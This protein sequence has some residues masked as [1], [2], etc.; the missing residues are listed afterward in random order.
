MHSENLLNF[1]YAGSNC[2]KYCVNLHS[3]YTTQI[4]I[5]AKLVRVWDNLEGRQVCSGCVYPT[6]S[7][8]VRSKGQS[9]DLFEF[10]SMTCCTYS[11]SDL[12]TTSSFL[13][14]SHA[15]DPMTI[16]TLIMWPLRV[17]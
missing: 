13:Y 5:G 9:M 14:M 3:I 10:S 8:Q 4:K 16:L 12:Q 11:S 6:R 2:L 17:F 15:L 7:G 1:D